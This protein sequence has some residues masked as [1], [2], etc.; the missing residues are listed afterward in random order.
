[1]L[2]ILK[3]LSY[4]CGMNGAKSGGTSAIEACFIAFG[5]H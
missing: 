2:A 3:D 4:L 5:L 1:M